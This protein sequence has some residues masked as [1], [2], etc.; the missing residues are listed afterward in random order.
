[1]VSNC[2]EEEGRLERIKNQKELLKSQIDEITI[3]IEDMA[4][5]GFES[6]KEIEML[7]SQI[8][9]ANAKVTNNVENKNRYE[10]EIE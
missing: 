7:N 2:N 10:S 5:L 6:Q 3:K 8:N 9:V 1:M 4:S